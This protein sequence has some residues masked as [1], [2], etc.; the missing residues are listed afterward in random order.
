MALPLGAVAK[1]ALTLAAIATKKT[2]QH[3]QNIPPSPRQTQ[4]ATYS[5]FSTFL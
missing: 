3:K 5:P 4:P 2:K 1:K